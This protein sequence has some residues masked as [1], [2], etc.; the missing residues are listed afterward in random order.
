MRLGPLSSAGT[1]RSSFIS[2]HTHTH[3]HTHTHVQTHGHT[4]T[5][6]LIVQRTELTHAKG[7][8]ELQASRPFPV[9]ACFDCKAELMFNPVTLLF[10]TLFR[11]LAETPAALSPWL[12]RL[13]CHGK[14]HPSGNP[15]PGLFL[16]RGG[17]TLTPKPQAGTGD[18]L[19][20]LLSL[21]SWIDHLA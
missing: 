9:P 13:Q 6:F 10:H 7:N 14:S 16:D 8:T 21:H 17:L 5:L 12:L 18:P 11:S 1:V 2:W 20:F 19:S 4:H 3:T 15:L